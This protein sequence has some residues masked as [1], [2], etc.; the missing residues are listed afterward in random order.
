MRKIM[1]QP[2]NVYS[3]YGASGTTGVGKGNREDLVDAVYDI[4]PTDTPIL[5]ALPRGKATAVLHEWTTH[6][7]AAAAANEKVEG[8]DGVITP[9]SRRPA[10]TTAAR[11]R[12]RSQ[13][14]RRPSRPSTRSA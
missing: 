3:V 4:S 6:A 12:T 11:S 5:T 1:A 9:R 13:A 14:S 8:D 10:S 2:T 7:L